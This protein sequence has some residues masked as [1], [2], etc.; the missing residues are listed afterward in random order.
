VLLYVKP[1]S[2]GIQCRSAANATAGKLLTIHAVVTDDVAVAS[3]TFTVNGTD[4]FTSTVAPYEFNYPV[5]AGTISL[6]ISARATDFG[7][8]VGRS[9][10]VTLPAA[11]GALRFLPVTPTFLWTGFLERFGEGR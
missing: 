1:N 11:T 7:G 3:V 6:T 10:E 4:V 8:N 9:S 5:P 2:D